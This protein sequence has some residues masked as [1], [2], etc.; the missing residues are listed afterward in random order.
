M[1]IY[2]PGMVIASH[3]LGSLL[4]DVSA[5]PPPL[6]LGVRIMLHAPSLP[7]C[8]DPDAAI[9]NKFTGTVYY[10]EEIQAVDFWLVISLI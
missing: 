1:G 4:K 5:S 2:C 3:D 6:R 9:S 7:I 10:S 8:T